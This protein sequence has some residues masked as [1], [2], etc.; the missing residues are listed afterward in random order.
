MVLVDFD[1]FFIF[2]F[3]VF[4]SQFY[5]KAKY[6]PQFGY[7]HREELFRG[8]KSRLY[9]SMIQSACD[10]PPVYVSQTGFKKKICNCRFRF[11]HLPT[12]LYSILE[13]NLTDLTLFVIGQ[14]NLQPFLRNNFSQ[15]KIS[16]VFQNTPNRFDPFYQTFHRMFNP[17]PTTLSK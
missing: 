2:H 1:W 16:I 13:Q 10:C 14:R 9:Y 12:G 7:S 17:I 6:M 15:K 5:K 11:V 3:L 8:L 4:F